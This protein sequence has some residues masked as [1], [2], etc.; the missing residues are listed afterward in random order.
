MVPQSMGNRDR[1]IARLAAD[2]GG[3]TLALVGAALIPLM[4][5]IGS[6][7]DMSRAY[8][9][10]SRLQT[11][12]DAAS[13][14]GRKAMTG[15]TLT[16][17]ARNE[18]IKFFNFNFEQNRYQTAAFTPTVT[19][20][21]AGTVQVSAATSIPTAVM[22]MFGFNSIPL[23]VTCQATQNFVNTDI[24]LVL[25]VTGSM[26]ESLNG[27]VKMT[28][29]RDAV[30]AFY[31][32]LAPVQAELQAAGMRLRYS[33]V[34]YS[35]TVNV[36]RL[37]HSRNASYI[38]DSWT[39]QSRVPIHYTAT[40]QTYTNRTSSECGAYSQPKTPGGDVFPA[41]QKYATRQNTNTRS[42]CYVTTV[43]YNTD[44]TGQFSGYYL[45]AGVV[46]D[47]SDYKT[48]STSVPLP[49][50]TPGSST[51]SSAWAGCIE[52]RQTVDSINASSGYS[53]PADA[54]DLDIDRIP[55]DDAS[56]W[57]PM[58]AQVA[59][60][61]YNQL[62][63]TIVASD[64]DNLRASSACPAE[65]RRLQAFTRA[66]MQTYVNNLQPTGSTYHDTGMIWGARMISDA[67]VFADS[68]ETFNS[69][70]VT[71]H[72]I[73]MTDGELAPTSQV[74]GMYGQERYD[75]RVTG[76]YDANGQYASHEQRFKMMCNATKGKKVSLW[77][78]A[79]GA[80]ASPALSECASNPDQLAVIDGSIDASGKTSRDRLIAK[81]REIGKSIGALRLRQ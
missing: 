5:M 50:R 31:D 34:P 29:M 48:G 16:D 44:G 7:V 18:A 80:T 14:A 23:T 2:T 52:E 45:H 58:W 40:Q 69:M 8:M 59:Y 55:S 46:Q 74:Y 22:H 11:A 21:A 75:Q 79:F 3:N 37:L 39:Y 12:C 61:R 9:A 73:F 57:K 13:L 26:A 53:L 25:D 28:S 42:D 62:D 49:T 78:I 70:P 56:R 19:R 27:A 10:K 35:S 32:E 72:V 81:F 20:P 38:A 4:A 6:G 30:M 76:R 24:V 17:P 66:D 1:A 33:V 77:V 60:G 67:G 36:G 64:S 63:D 71:K 65:A 15:D 43:T 51:N 41:T 47:T 54:W 68:P